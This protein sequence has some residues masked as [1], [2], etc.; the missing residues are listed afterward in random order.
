MTQIHCEPKSED[1]DRY[2]AVVAKIQRIV[3]EHLQS[4]KI[5]QAS[6]EG[7]TEDRE[8]ALAQRSFPAGH[9]RSS[10]VHFIS[11]ELSESETSFINSG[12]AAAASP[13]EGGMLAQGSET[14]FSGHLSPQRQFKVGG[15]VNL[16]GKPEA[17][18]NWLAELD[19][20][21]QTPDELNRAFD[22]A[23]QQAADLVNLQERFMGRESNEFMTHLQPMENLEDSAT[24]DLL[25]SVIPPIDWS[26]YY[27]E[28]NAAQENQTIQRG[29]TEAAALSA[30]GTVEQ[31]SKFEKFIPSKIPVF[32]FSKLS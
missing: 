18:R 16:E 31:A 1:F 26:E 5:L 9:S 21:N 32:D 4:K 28:I 23:L 11:S 13:L 3:S 22:D 6:D 10:V 7:D 14:F 20:A 29:E 12:D 25:K 2:D 24:E 30:T 8:S 19:V 17:L 27:E 15:P